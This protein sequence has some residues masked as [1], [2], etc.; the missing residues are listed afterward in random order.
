MDVVLSGVRTVAVVRALLEVRRMKLAHPDTF[1]RRSGASI[2]M[3]QDDRGGAVIQRRSA[4]D[5][6]ERDIAQQSLTSGGV[7]RS[8]ERDH[9]RRDSTAAG[10]GADGRAFIGDVGAG[11][12]DLAS[13]G[14]GVA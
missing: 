11:N 13:A 6:A 3:S 4:A 8:V 1:T 7:G 12:T 10:K 5:V 9:Q 2:R 14:S